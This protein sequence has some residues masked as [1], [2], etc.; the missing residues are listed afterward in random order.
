MGVGGEYIQKNQHEII[1][2]GNSFMAFKPRKHSAPNKGIYFASQHQVAISLDLSIM[3]Q[4]T[5]EIPPA[6]LKLQ[7]NSCFSNHKRIPETFWAC[8]VHHT[9]L[10]VRRQVS[11]WTVFL[12]SVHLGRGFFDNHLWRSRAVVSAFG[13]SHRFINSQ[14]SWVPLMPLELLL[15]LLFQILVSLFSRAFFLMLSHAKRQ[16]DALLVWWWNWSWVCTGL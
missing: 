14:P 8:D 16:R 1:N 7:P 2:V 12:V 13:D 9:K 6:F 5:I 10:G 11:L 15:K 3:L 4:P